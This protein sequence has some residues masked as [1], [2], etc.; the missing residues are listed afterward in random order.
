[1]CD[2]GKGHRERERVP[3]LSSADPTTF[4]HV[5]L[6]Q[7]RDPYYDTTCTAS[8]EATTNWQGGTTNWQGGTLP[9]CVECRTRPIQTSQLTHYACAVQVPIHYSAG[10]PYSPSYHM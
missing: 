3:A 6:L 2:G 10:T 8:T 1:M 4:E 9:I 7:L 5:S